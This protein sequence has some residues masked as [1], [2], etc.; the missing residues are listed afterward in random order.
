MSKTISVESIML[1]MRERVKELNCLYKVDEILRDFESPLKDIMTKIAEVIKDAWQYPQYCCV[2]IILN[3]IEYYSKDFKHSEWMQ[4]T[5]IKSEEKIFGSINVYYKQNLPKADEGPFLK[6]ER[7]LL[8]TIGEKIG[9]YIYYRN[10]KGFFDKYAPEEDKTL[11]KI[12]DGKWRAIVDLLKGTDRNLYILIARKM[13]NH[14][15][16]SGVKEASSLL[17]DVGVK[18][19][20]ELIE[21]IDDNKPLAKIKFKEMTDEVFKIAAE[22]MSEEEILT[23]LEKW[24][25]EDK[26]SYLLRKLED[27]GSSLNELADLL[28][29][30]VAEIPTNVKL[31]PELDKSLRVSLIRRFLSD[32]LSYI[33]IAKK[34]LT[35]N[36]FHNISKK[37]IFTSNSHGKLGGKSAGLIL[38]TSILR[39]EAPEIYNKIRVPKT[40]YI[41]SD[42]I[43][44]FIHYNNLE[45]VFE[46]KYKDIDIIRQEYPYIV[47]LF[48][49]SSFSPDMLKNFSLMLDDFGNKP[50]VV[51]SSTLLEDGIG[52]AFSGKYKSLFLAN[53]GSKKKCLEE[54]TSAVAEVYASIFNTD[55]IE[56]RAERGLL[57]YNE[58]M[59]V[60]IQEVVGVQVGKYYL[61]AFAGVAFS[62]NEFRWSPR[63]KREDGLIRL[64]PGLGTRAVDRTSDD[65]PILVSPGLPTLK[66]N[67]T[68]EETLKY[69]P[70][71][72]DVI[73]LETNTF[74]TIEIKDLLREYGN[75]YPM[76][77]KIFSVYKDGHVQRGF[78]LDYK[79]EWNN[80]I[81]TFENLINST[82]FVKDMHTMISTLKKSV[83]HPVDIEFAC[84]GENIYLLQCRTQSSFEDINPS[85]IPKDVPKEKIIFTANRYISNGRVP[86]ITHIVYVDPEAYSEISDLSTLQ[87][88]GRAVG[89]LN[90]LLPKRQFIL[91][92]PG[93]WGSRGDIRLGV[94]VTYSD[95]NN[96]AVLIEIAKKKGNYVPDLSFGTHFFQDLVESSIRYIPL[97]PDDTGIIFNE[98]FLKSSKNILT[99]LLPEYKHLENIIRV[100]DV[101][102]RTNGEILRILLN[103]E[104]DEALAFLSQPS[105]RPEGKIYT[106]TQETSKSDFHW[107][108]RMRMVEKI[109]SVIDTKKFGIKGLYVFGS[110]KNGSAGPSS[111]IDLLIHFEGTEEQKNNL[112]LWLEA[113]GI[114][115]AEMNYQRTGY[116][117][118]NLLDVHIITDKDIE[119]KNSYALKIG[120][121]TDAAKK[122]ETF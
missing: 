54:L 35:I 120:A 103:S 8:N 49:N 34:Y 27:Q 39:E 115:L 102:E 97:Y 109:A 55:P 42:G 26:S 51:R 17:Q 1:E 43:M 44:D 104:L 14:L 15:Y 74:E 70:K 91:M 2:K 67:V 36:D 60:I 96:T 85:P 18:D 75:E 41:I 66:V 63:I 10:L 92:G 98:T 3:D 77:D 89:K 76:V 100:I 117:S 32:A 101:K 46:Q 84:D 12:K 116:K 87:D 30:Y 73:N 23:K 107:K 25:Q 88:V 72:I 105:G 121:V 45:E 122:L 93:R 6:E 16:W 4:S 80:S 31:A 82:D 68:F 53:Q 29:R 99:Y 86:E 69:S 21:G 11:D 111:D 37:V 94:S 112:L 90:K 22:Y 79:K 78:N 118:T 81:A 40:W 110:T 47:Q 52:A 61:P 71:R 95:I 19:M 5:D 33:G 38:A 48:K 24:I 106:E 28:R 59:G 20:E 108:W 113:W 114:A 50:L 56:Y 65:Y 83:N 62:N 7:K 58:Q 9:Q 64:V 57:D 119:E 13:M